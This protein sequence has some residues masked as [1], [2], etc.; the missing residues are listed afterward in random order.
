M[1]LLRDLLVLGVALLPLG[2]LAYLRFEP[3]GPAASLGAVLLVPGSTAY[4]DLYA[5]MGRNLAAQGLRV[6][7]IDVRG[8]G[9]STCNPDGECSDPPDGG[10]ST[11]VDD[12]YFVGRR[13]TTKN[14]F[15]RA[16][17]KVSYFALVPYYTPY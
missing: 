10:Y 1:S 11:G 16:L 8:H 3:S 9:R 5:E 14:E 4:A 15:V 13:R 17:R 7:I 2:Y 12:T 6:R